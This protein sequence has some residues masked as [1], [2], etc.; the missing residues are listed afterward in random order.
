[1]FFVDK[2]QGLDLILALKD[3]NLAS[4]ASFGEFI[5]IFIPLVKSL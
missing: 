3:N 1:V 2:Y 5:S 4:S